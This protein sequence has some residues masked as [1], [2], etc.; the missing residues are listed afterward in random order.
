MISSSS[1]IEIAF[2]F[3]GMTISTWTSRYHQ[4]LPVGIVTHGAFDVLIGQRI[5]AGPVG[6]ALFAARP[7]CKD[8]IQGNARDILFGHCLLPRGPK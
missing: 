5:D 2:F 3:C 7:P 6:F 1:R 8:F 4:I